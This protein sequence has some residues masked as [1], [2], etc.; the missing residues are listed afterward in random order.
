MRTAT[1]RVRR[2]LNR[3]ANNAPGVQR[4]GTRRVRASDTRS[5]RAT[6]TARL[7]TF[8]FRPTLE[9]RVSDDELK[10]HAA[11]SHRQ[12]DA[13][14]GVTG[15]RTQLVGCLSDRDFVITSQM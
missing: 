12:L 3:G 7:W 8:M 9:A 1:W 4:R 13:L 14:L 2:P 11:P 10:K 6:A 15:M 5:S